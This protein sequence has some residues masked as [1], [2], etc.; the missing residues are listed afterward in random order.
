M[1]LSLTRI[2]LPQIATKV[3]ANA[4]TSTSVNGC[5]L[6]PSSNRC[7]GQNCIWAS[8]RGCRRLSTVLHSK[9]LLKEGWHRRHYQQSVVTWV[10]VNSSLS[11]SRRK[12]SSVKKHH[13]SFSDPLKWS[14]SSKPELFEGSWKLGWFRC[15]ND[16]SNDVS[17][18]PL[19]KLTKLLDTIVW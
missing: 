13:L 5:I 10:R 4:P 11:S 8:A 12:A 18:Y 17:H 16:N 14:T 7:L 1:N 3:M 19:V 6:T 2:K 9:F 15:F